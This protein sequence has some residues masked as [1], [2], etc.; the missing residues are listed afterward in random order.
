MTFYFF[1]FRLNDF[2]INILLHPGMET[3]EFFSVVGPPHPNRSK[4]QVATVSQFAQ[5]KKTFALFNLRTSP[6]ELV[7]F[8]PSTRPICMSLIKERGFQSRKNKLA[9]IRY[10]FGENW[11]LTSTNR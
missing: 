11:H 8:P 2:K 10:F 5:I 4:R 7:L 1:S 3:I 6:D 9:L